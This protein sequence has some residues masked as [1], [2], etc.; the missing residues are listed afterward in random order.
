MLGAFGGAYAALGAQ[1][2]CS[3]ASMT[4]GGHCQYLESGDRVQGCQRNLLF[5]FPLA[6]GKKASS[7]LALR[8]PQSP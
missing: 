6:I 7:L 2:A 5:L 3:A 4:G 8:L 1:L